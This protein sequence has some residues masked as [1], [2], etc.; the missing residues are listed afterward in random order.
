MRIAVAAVSL[1]ALVGPLGPS[2]HADA[3]KPLANWTPQGRFFD[4]ALAVSADGSRVLAVATDAATVSSLHLFNAGGEALTVDQLPP[5]VKQVAFLGNDRVIAIASHEGDSKLVGLTA[6]VKKGKDGKPTF[7]LDS[8]HL[9][10]ADASSTSSTARRA[11][12]SSCS[13]TRS[14]RR[15]PSIKCRSSRPRR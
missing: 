12:A 8:K 2:A 5:T 10:P 6:T 9:G 11:S 7:T 15:R 1:L 4:D 14:R 13:A 3:P